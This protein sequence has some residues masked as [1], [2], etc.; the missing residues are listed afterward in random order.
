MEIGSSEWFKDN[1]KS[2]NYPV[3]IEF[4]LGSKRDSLEY[5]E[6][7]K[8]QLQKEAKT[9]GLEDCIESKDIIS[10]RELDR[11]FD[12]IPIVKNFSDENGDISNIPDESVKNKNS[13]ND[14]ENNSSDINF[15]DE[16][17]YINWLRNAVDE[18][19]KGVTGSKSKVLITDSGLLNLLISLYYEFCTG[20][21]D[22]KNVGEDL[23]NEC[24]NGVHKKNSLGN[25]VFYRLIANTFE[26]DISEIHNL[27]DPDELVKRTDS[28][29]TVLTLIQ[30]LSFSLQYS[31]ITFVI[32]DNFRITDVKIE[33]KDDDVFEDNDKEELDEESYGEIAYWDEECGDKGY[34]DIN[35]I[36]NDEKRIT[37][38]DNICYGH[39]MRDL[40][41]D[42][43]EISQKVCYLNR[44]YTLEE[45]ISKIKKQI[46]RT[47]YLQGE[48]PILV[49]KPIAEGIHTVLFGKPN[50][51]G[52]IT[53]LNNK[54]R[55]NEKKYRKAVAREAIARKA[56]YGVSNDGLKKDVPNEPTKKSMIP[57]SCLPRMERD[58]QKRIRELQEIITKME[59]QCT[60]MEELLMLRARM[61]GRNVKVTKPDKTQSQ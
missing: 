23:F 17:Y 21:N 41:P 49:D 45:V 50:K 9:D 1:I 53:R 38:Y 35:Y 31:P 47:I 61:K 46:N 4:I 29:D 25:E 13:P 14:E 36:E 30:K 3:W 48:D 11:L 19:T 51:D 39:C 8:E 42:F 56:Q 52:K 16:N 22:A 32:G 7:L 28:I 27:L 58:R 6:I 24:K 44:D 54:G 34:R 12:F 59:E 33:K 10:K 2:R 5:A 20:M 26:Y 43:R 57:V 60:S 40:E 15:A 37:E 55:I 18:I